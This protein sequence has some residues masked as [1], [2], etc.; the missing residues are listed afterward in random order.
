[1]NGHSMKK[2]AA[3]I[4]LYGTKYQILKKKSSVK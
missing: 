1:M 3:E 4:I 2:G